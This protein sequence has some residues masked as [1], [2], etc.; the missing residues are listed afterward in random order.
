MEIDRRRRYWVF[1]ALALVAVGLLLW[2]LLHKKTPK[3]APPP[4]IPVTAAK[5][6][7]RD[8]PIFVSA[9]GAAQAWTSDTVFAQ[10][11]GKLLRVNFTEGS[12]VR[13]G[14][15]LAEVDPAPYRAVLDQ[16]LGT[17]HR[18]QAI[19][20]GATRDLTRY[21]HLLQTNAIPRQTVEDE[22]A[23]VAQ[24]KGIVQVD[25][26]TVASARINLNW[27]R[28]VAPVSGRAGVRLVDP[29]NIVSASG[30]IAS[31][32]ATASATSSASA[33]GSGGSGIVVINQ[34]E[35]IA[36]TFTVPE[37][38][39]EQLSALSNGFSKPLAVQALSQESGDLLDT[40]Q[41]RIAD[42]KVDPATGTVE[43]K[44]RFTNDRKR[45]WPGQFI[46]VKLAAQTLSHATVIPTAAINRGPK[47]SYVFVVGVDGKAVMHPIQIVGSEGAFTAVGKG[48]NPGDTVVTDGQMTLKP[49]SLVRIVQPAPAAS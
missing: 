17:L 18:D 26:G 8:L 25:Q 24:D 43:L 40:G 37:G 20:A 28:I 38:Q 23:T 5:A 2:V 6:V 36:V 3:P 4:P 16:A 41:L 44:A 14:Q 1:G 7:A 10:V 42:N 31:T 21:Q 13:A 32:P 30:S 22:E 29:G 33:T 48:V 11:N 19:L 45:L 15:V 49:G 46:D 39:F 27:C 9:L 12:D 34:I 35:P 47:G